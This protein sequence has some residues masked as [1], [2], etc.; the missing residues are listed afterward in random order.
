[1]SSSHTCPCVKAA[2]TIVHF[3][4]PSGCDY[5]HRSRENRPYTWIKEAGVFQVG[6]KSLSVSQEMWPDL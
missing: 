6:T 1:M 3:A 2:E 4:G 5:R